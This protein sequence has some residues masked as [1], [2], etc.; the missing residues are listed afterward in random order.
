MGYDGQIPYGLEFATR[1][2]EEATLLGY[3]YAYEQ[4]SRAR[5]APPLV[6]PKLLTGCP[7]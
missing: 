3:A 4:A 1:P 2:F 6:N 7:P 5:A